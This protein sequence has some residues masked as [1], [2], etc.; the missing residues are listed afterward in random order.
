MKKL[1]SILK[2]LQLLLVLPFSIS[3]GSKKR[4][5]RK[6]KKLMIQANLL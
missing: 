2:V 3:N 6:I 5:Y 1:L 4:A